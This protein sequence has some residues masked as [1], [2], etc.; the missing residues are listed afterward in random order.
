MDRGP[1]Q[2][3]RLFQKFLDFLTH[4]ILKAVQEA[5]LFGCFGRS[6]G[7]I[8]VFEDHDD[9]L[10]QGCRRIWRGEVTRLEIGDNFRNTSGSCSE[11]GGFRKHRLH[12]GLR[13][14]FAA[15]AC[16]DIEVEASEVGP[17]VGLVTQKMDAIC[18]ARGGGSLL[19]IAFAGASSDEDEMVVRE[20]LRDLI[21]GCHDVVVA[22]PVAE[23]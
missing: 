2:I 16:E 13:D 9:G 10:R 23:N 5:P 1:E 11:E 21:E 20:F 6:L 14:A 7:L 4:E 22:F 8:R 18:A 17:G 12:A 3:V 15:G 19:Q